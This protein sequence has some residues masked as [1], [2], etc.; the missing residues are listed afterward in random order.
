MKKISIAIDGPSG[1]GKTT[2][3]KRAAGEFGFTHV[4]T[5]AIYRVVGL[6]VF[7]AGVDPKDAQGVCALLDRIKID[8]EYK[9]CDQR[10]IL[11]GED[12]TGLIRTHEISMYASDVSA[13]PAVRDFLLNM[14]RDLATRYDVIMDGRDIATV[15]LPNAQ[16]KIFLTA[17]SEDRAQRRYLELLG[18]G[19]QIDFQKVLDDVVLR[20]KN[21][22]EREIA[23]L[24]PAAD[25][26][27]VDTTGN[28]L[29]QSLDQ[30]LE[31]IRNALK[32]EQN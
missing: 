8:I 15:V 4:D 29:E 19:Q 7:R 25:S 10:M 24:K 18:R 26:I 9:D 6:F 3:S 1:A 27:I 2:I 23:P 12:V 16:V 13:I 17:S 21:D 30:L 14:Q 31:I 32:Q 11:N 5:G 22:S 20:D 28:T